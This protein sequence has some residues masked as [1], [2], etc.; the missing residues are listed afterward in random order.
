MC[1][2]LLIV[3]SAWQIARDNGLAQVTLRD[4]ADLVGMRP[5]SL[6]SH[7][8]AKNAIY[9]AMF[10]DAWIQFLEAHKLAVAGSWIE[11]STCSPTTSASP[12]KGPTHDR[13]GVTPQPGRAAR[14]VDR[15]RAGDA[16]RSSRR[17]G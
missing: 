16:A 2:E 17:T 7:F 6:Y 8:A 1:A 9:D 14:L 3:E 12:T 4:V 10:G 13:A 15:P 11:P 5:P